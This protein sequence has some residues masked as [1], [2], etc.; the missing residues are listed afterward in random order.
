MKPSNTMNTS[1]EVSGSGSGIVGKEMMNKA[2]SSSANRSPMKVMNPNNS[3]KSPT[4]V[5]RNNAKVAAMKKRVKRSSVIRLEHHGQLLS[6]TTIRKRK[7]ITT[8]LTS[9]ATAPPDHNITWSEKKQRKD[10]TTRSP[11][12]SLYSKDF[13]YQDV[14]N[15]KETKL[16]FLGK[17]GSTL[18]ALSFAAYALSCFLP[19][20][21]Q[22][23]TIVYLLPI[24]LVLFTMSRAFYIVKTAKASSFWNMHTDVLEVAFLLFIVSMYNIQHLMDEDGNDWAKDTLM[25]TCILCFAGAI[26]CNTFLTK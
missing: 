2:D 24:F 19:H 7:T 8:D 22:T 9:L 26:C 20:H 4:S 11:T 25:L 14:D 17:L 21:V 18:K 3:I 12:P 23:A 1:L 13:Q 6:P 10:D 16:T 15:K 5:P